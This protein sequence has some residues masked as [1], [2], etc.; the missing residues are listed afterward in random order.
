M[1]GLSRA[2]MASTALVLVTTPG[3]FAESRWTGTLDNQFNHFENWDGSFNGSDLVIDGNY[4][5]TAPGTVAT[6]INAVDTSNNAGNGPRSLVI[7]GGATLTATYNGAA[8]AIGWT[9]GTS[10]ITVTGAGSQLVTN[11]GSWTN[12]GWGADTTGVLTVSDGATFQA[13]HHIAVGKGTG[14]TGRLE[15][16]HA[17]LD[18]RT[19]AQLQVGTGGTGTVDVTNGS[20]ATLAGAAFIGNSA[21]AT[22]SFNLSGG[23][24]LTS[25][26]YFLLG[27]STGS[28]GNATLSDSGTEATFSGQFYAGYTGAGNFTVESGAHAAVSGNAY[29]GHNASSTGTVVVTGTG[30]FLSVTGDVMLGEAGTGNMTVSNGA[31]T[32]VNGSLSAGAG[33]YYDDDN[34]TT[35]YNS[36]GTGTLTVTGANTLLVVD[37]M[38]YAGNHG[39]GTVTLSD[40]GEIRAGAVT[41]AAETGSSGTFNIGAAAGDTATAA[42]TLGVTDVIFG[43]GTGK[44]V[45]NHTNSDYALNAAVRGNGTIRTLAGVTRLTGDYTDYTGAVAVDG[46]LLS[47]DTSSFTQNAFTVGNEGTLRVTRSVS[48]ATDTVTMTGGS[49]INTGSI[50]GTRYGVE[51]NGSDASAITTSGSINGGTA[52]I[53]YATGG[54]SLTVLTGAT[55]GNVIDYNNTA[56]NTTIF[57]KGS[58]SIPVAH[59]LADDNTV[60]LSGE[61]QM[62]VYGNAASGSGTINVVDAGTMASQF[63]SVQTVTSS[64]ATTAADVLSVDVDRGGISSRVAMAYDDADKKNEN[65]KAI[66]AMVGDGLAVDAQGNLFWMRA[67]GG[68]SHDDYSDTSARHFGVALGADHMFGQT[69]VGLLGG[70]GKLKNDTG[71]DT[72]SAT[73]DTVFGGVYV[74]QPL[75]GFMLDASLI[76]G[77]IFADTTRAVK[78]GLETARGSY[79]GWFVSPE[80]ALSRAY[81]LSDGWTLTPRGSV[82]YTYGSFEG[83]GET[84][85]SLDITYDDRSTQAVESAFE[86]KLSKAHRF[87][88]GKVAT[89]SVTAAALDTYNLGDTGFNASVTGTDFTVSSMGDRNRVGGRVGLGGELRLDEKATL[90]GGV[91]ATGYTDDSW[92]VVGNAGLKV[93]F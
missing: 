24:T 89:V 26:D 69:R 45:F 15:I 84:G 49:L 3:A 14:S 38:V 88:S 20:T 66:S 83:Y 51:L 5:V 43:D 68:A 1:F 78:G 42:G 34:L 63:T 13:G 36:T 57:G 46:G 27:L 9:P 29:V 76:G 72:A 4:S 22:G 35:S 47:I 33:I 30:S 23:S 56:G 77:G 12:I 31:R 87:E 61:R 79:D 74:R 81:A 39:V 90:F 21:N 41:I 93:Q 37:G 91:S 92:S 64:I 7:S 10:T 62:A 11:S 58:F 6:D 44:L 54:N 40:G 17:T 80:L 85:S 67:F 71:D 53:H 2:L 70:I 86:L 75:S 59:Y 18:L 32:I 28:T 8:I 55:F 65:Q 52:A 50:S 60:A 16:D 73:G 25:S 48:G 82:R 19:G